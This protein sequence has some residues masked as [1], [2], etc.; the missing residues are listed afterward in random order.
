LGGSEVAFGEPGID[1]WGVGW[2]VEFEFEW[3]ADFDEVGMGTVDKGDCEGGADKVAVFGKRVGWGSRKGGEE[4][5]GAQDDGFVEFVVASEFGF[6]KL[7]FLDAGDIGVEGVRA[8][9]EERVEG[10]GSLV[11]N[12]FRRGGRGGVAFPRHKKSTLPSER[13]MERTRAE[14]TEFLSGASGPAPASIPRFAFKRN[15]IERAKGVPVA[16]KL[17]VDS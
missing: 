14:R 9:R 2:V 7:Y 3:R 15:R 16:E 5:V 17:I 11:W 8:F 13:V 1:L 12:P 6:A 4:V 10:E